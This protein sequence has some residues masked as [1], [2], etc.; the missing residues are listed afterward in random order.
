MISRGRKTSLEGDMPF[1]LASAFLVI[2]FNN[3]LTAAMPGYV[4]WQGESAFL[5][6]LQ[7][8]LF[9]GAAIMLR[10]FLGPLSDKAGSPT[11]L[12]VGAL[13]F[14]IPCAGL[15]W[16]T[17]YWQIVLLRIVQA[18]GLAAYHPNASAAVSML[19][20][21]GRRGEW[22]GILRCVT[23][24]SLM[25]GPAVLFPII[26]KSGY[27]AFFGISCAIAL[28]GALAALPIKF[29]R[30]NARGDKVRRTVCPSETDAPCRRLFFKSA[31]PLLI[32]PFAIAGTF[33]ILLNFGA[34]LASERGLENAGFIFTF[35]SIGGLAGSLIAGRAADTFGTWRTV[36]ICLMGAAMGFLILSWTWSG[37]IALTLGAILAGAGYYGTTV[38]AV[39]HLGANAGSARG[40]A[41]SMQQNFLDMGIACGGLA[42][43]AILSIGMKTAGLC[44]VC[45][46]LL[47]IGCA[48]WIALPWNR[49][50]T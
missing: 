35:M 27:P 17:N 20:P 13:G 15:A 4:M 18:I 19:A 5:G 21:A 9:I 12:I 3:T 49:Q 47:A 43:G 42:G 28:G 22:M 34:Q 29:R 1:L 50:E 45:T 46:V 8:F 23:T 44:A 11:M 38:A 32:F 6:A 36:L 30:G 7:N 37:E 2:G 16:C 31:W 33:G 26:S 48:L 10:F 24:L 25:V 40:Y 39:A 41:L 14:F